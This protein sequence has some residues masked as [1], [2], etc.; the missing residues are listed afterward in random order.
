MDSASDNEDCFSVQ[1]EGSDMSPKAPK[2]ASNRIYV[3][4]DGCPYLHS[5]QTIL[6]KRFPM[7]RYNLEQDGRLTNLVKAME[8]VAY[9]L[10]PQA[11]AS[12]IVLCE[13][14]ESLTLDSLTT[15]LPVL[16]PPIVPPT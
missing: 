2:V 11:S 9:G 15:S 12:V 5:I 16:H 4:H 10:S 6:R 8:C 7:R 3:C 1:L 14:T 13:S